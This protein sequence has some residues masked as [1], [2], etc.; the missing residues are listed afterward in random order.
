L[1]V[2]VIHRSLFVHRNIVG[3]FV[4]L[5]I[6]APGSAAPV[7]DRSAPPAAATAPAIEIDNFGRVSDHYYRGAQPEAN[8]LSDLVKLGIKTTIDLTNG[9]GNGSE[10]RVAE[11]LGMKFFKIPMSTRVVPTPE[12]ISQ[13]LSIVDD[14][15]NQPVYVHCVG[16]KHRT[17]VMTAIYRMIEDG[18]APARAFQ[19]MK[20]YKFG[21]D[22]LHPEFKKF[23]AAFKSSPLAFPLMP[24]TPVKQPGAPSS[25]PER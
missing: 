13:F 25:S 1:E 22:F 10:Q 5:S 8:D 24:P 11:G 18:W 6:A 3:L 20:S 15:A 23:V 2:S 4:A 17:G 16:G 21:A 12:Q 9:D 19:E 14:P 7:K